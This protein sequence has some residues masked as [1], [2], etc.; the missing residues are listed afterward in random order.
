MWIIIGNGF[1][2]SHFRLQM[3]NIST[4]AGESKQ[5]YQLI[6][7]WLTQLSNYE[8]DLKIFVSH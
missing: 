3:E 1:S 2:A 6:D 5:A 7:T 8:V 4:A